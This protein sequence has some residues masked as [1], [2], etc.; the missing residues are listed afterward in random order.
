VKQPRSRTSGDG[1]SLSRMPLRPS[2]QALNDIVQVQRR[3]RA[4][5]RRHRRAPHGARVRPLQSAR[6]PR[7][8]RHPRCARRCRASL[9][10]C[11]SAASATSPA[12][13]NAL[14]AAATSVAAARCAASMPPPCAAQNRSTSSADGSALA[15]RGRPGSGPARRGMPAAPVA[16]G[17]RPPPRRPWRRPSRVRLPRGAAQGVRWRRHVVLLAKCPA[18]ATLAHRA[19]SRRAETLGLLWPPCGRVSTGPTGRIRLLLAVGQPPGGRA[20]PLGRGRAQSVVRKTGNEQQTRRRV[21]RR[22]L[23]TQELRVVPV[24]LV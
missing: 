8:R 13:E 21:V 17:P 20:R 2:L 16:A 4:S 1:R 7:A 5:T 24:K 15:L 3:P 23:L 10:R 14:K 18:H 6:T 19:S 11:R 12:A 22:H 9:T